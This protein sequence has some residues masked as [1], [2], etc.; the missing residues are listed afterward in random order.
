[1]SASL[2]LIISHIAQAC[3]LSSQS[4]PFYVS[5][6]ALFPIFYRQ[7][8]FPQ[9]SLSYTSFLAL[10]IGMFRCLELVCF[11]LDTRLLLVCNYKA[12]LFFFNLFKIFEKVQKNQKTKKLNR[13]I[14]YLWQQLSRVA[15]E[16]ST[17]YH[18]RWLG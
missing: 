5:F 4:K 12:L 1:M 15:F 2:T 18:I 9:V 10:S 13:K 16:Q 6:A 17:I 11:P 7:G 14:C 8:A 3:L